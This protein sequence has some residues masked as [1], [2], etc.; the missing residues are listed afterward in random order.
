[1][2]GEGS[3]VEP[4][5]ISEKRAAAKMRDG[6]FQMKAVGDGNGDD[7]IVVRRKDGG[8]LADAFGV[9]ALGEADKELAAD[10]KDITAF[11]SAGKRDVFELAELVEGLG[12]R[13]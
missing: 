8:K 12:E 5:A 1:M 9:A 3:S 10:A 6:R 13:R 7:F 2:G 4:G 11:E